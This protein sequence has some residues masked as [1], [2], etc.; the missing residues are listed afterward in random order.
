MYRKL[1]FTK[2]LIITLLYQH[3]IRKNVII[4][5]INV[6]ISIKRHKLVSQYSNISIILTTNTQIHYIFY[7]FKI[8]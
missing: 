2:S 7:Y 3:K 6:R 1:N 4:F 5:E 8:H